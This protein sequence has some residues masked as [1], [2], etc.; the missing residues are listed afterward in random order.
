MYI[1]PKVPW[2]TPYSYTRYRYGGLHCLVWN[3]KNYIR[4]VLLGVLQQQQQQQIVEFVYLFPLLLRNGNKVISFSDNT[5][6]QL[7]LC[8]VNKFK[9]NIPF[10]QI[11]YTVRQV[12]KTVL[13]Q[14]IVY[15]NLRGIRKWSDLY[16]AEWPLFRFPNPSFIYA[17]L[18]LRMACLPFSVGNITIP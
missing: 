12:V 8:Q 3:V 2:R 13:L 17:I 1:C 15:Y 4:L 10:C 6:S 11:Q 16:S 7:P 14:L 5:L 9:V 18:L